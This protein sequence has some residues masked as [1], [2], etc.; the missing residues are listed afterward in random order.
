[1][2]NSSRTTDIRYTICATLAKAITTEV[3][4]TEYTCQS[5]L[6]RVCAETDVYIKDK[7][8]HDSSKGILLPKSSVEAFYVYEGEVLTIEGTAN[9][10]SIL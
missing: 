6:I 7:N 8:I 10:T 4:D 1:M 9:V 3:I 5:N 2:R